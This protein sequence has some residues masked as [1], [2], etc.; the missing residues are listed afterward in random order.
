MNK[1]KLEETTKLQ[2][3]RIRNLEKQQNQIAIEQLEKVK[4]QKFEFF[5]GFYVRVDVID[6]QINKLKKKEEEEYET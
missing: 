6:Q 1:T 5:S 4:E 3:I 2:A